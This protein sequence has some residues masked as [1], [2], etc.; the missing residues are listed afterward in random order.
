ME[1]LMKKS[2]NYYS[3]DNF[4]ANSPKFIHFTDIIECKFCS[5]IVV[6]PICYKSCDNIFCKKSIGDWLKRK[7]TLA[8]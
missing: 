4:S 3:L 6:D 1:S 2:E 5:G 8:H 7:K